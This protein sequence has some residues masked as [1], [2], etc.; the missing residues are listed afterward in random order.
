MKHWGVDGLSWGD[1]LEGL[2]AGKDQ[3]YFI[4]LSEGANERASGAI[5]NWVDLWWGDWC[6]APLQEMTKDH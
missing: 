1:T 2:M 5:C 3:L 6:G 4:P